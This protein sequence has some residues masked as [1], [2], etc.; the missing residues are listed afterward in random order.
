M[1][2]CGGLKVF[3]DSFLF[4]GQVAG[5]L[6]GHPKNFVS[7]A[8]SVDKGEALALQ[9][10]GFAGLG[11]LFDGEGDLALQGG[12][13]YLRSQGGLGKSQGQLAPD[14]VAPAL[15][16]GM[17]P[18]RYLHLQIPCG[19]AVLSGVALAA[20]GDHLSVVNTGGDVDTD[21]GGFA[22]L[23]GA[24]AGGTGFL[25]DLAPAMATGTDRLGLNHTEGGALLAAFLSR[26]A[27]LGTGLGRCALGRTGPFAVGTGV[28]DVD[29]YLLFAS[30][31]RFVKGQHHR[32]GDVAAP[33]GGIG[34]LAPAAA[35]SAASAE[36]GRKDVPQ[37]DVDV[38]KAVAW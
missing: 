14:I 7:P 13:R 36:E 28:D 15:E 16:Q 1:F 38:V 30:K 3:E 25:D 37:I 34:I 8:P 35:E 22:D 5:N 10:D 17:G 19:T 29:R 11:A 18:H 32:R 23:S 12:H 4:R 2:P 27:A 21:G 20:D 26:P 9:T 24:A 6:N 33:P 31:G